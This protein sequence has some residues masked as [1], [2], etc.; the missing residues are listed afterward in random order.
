MIDL[1]C[2]NKLHGRLLEDG[3]L[4]INCDSR[5]CGKEPGIVVL[6]RFKPETGELVETLKYKAPQHPTRTGKEG[7]NASR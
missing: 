7:L 5:F 4:E 2:G 3:L 6:H 1:H